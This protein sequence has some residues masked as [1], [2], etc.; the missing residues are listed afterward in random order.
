MKVSFHFVLLAFGAFLPP[1]RASSPWT[2]V[3]SMHGT[4]LMSAMIEEIMVPFMPCVPSQPD[5]LLEDVGGHLL[6]RRHVA[7]AA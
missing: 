1:S 6:W 4:T 3:S 5:V 7:A 2:S